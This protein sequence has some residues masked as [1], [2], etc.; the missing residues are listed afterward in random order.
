MHCRFAID[1][2]NPI[3]RI[4]FVVL[5]FCTS[6]EI[7]AGDELP[8]GIVINNIWVVRMASCII[9]VISL[10]RI[11]RFQWHNLS[12]DLSREDLGLIELGNVGFRNSLLFVAIVENCRSILTTFV[13]ALPI[14]LRGVMCD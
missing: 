5:S 13:G 1:G 4:I 7:V 9:L 12:D 10:C 2:D 6:P 14:E 8:W 3:G 11:K